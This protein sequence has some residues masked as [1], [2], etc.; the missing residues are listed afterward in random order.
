MS[1]PERYSST[2]SKRSGVWA[3]I[4]V[5]PGNTFASKI[6]FEKEA[7]FRPVSRFD[8]CGHCHVIC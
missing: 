4:Q 6:K 1:F 8:K 3:I 5:G 7:S 2:V